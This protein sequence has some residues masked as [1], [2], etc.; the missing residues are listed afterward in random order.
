MAENSDKEVEDDSLTCC[1]PFMTSARQKVKEDDPANVVCL[2]F[3]PLPE[4]EEQQQGQ[5]R[6]RDSQ[7]SVGVRQQE[8]Q[9]EEEAPISISWS[10]QQAFKG[11]IKAKLIKIFVTLKKLYYAK[12]WQNSMDIITS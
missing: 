7:S 3:T 2:S 5:G 9:E 10:S 12:N 6:G 11:E 1:L 8:S 4:E